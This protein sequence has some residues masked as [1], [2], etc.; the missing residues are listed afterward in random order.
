MECKICS[1]EVCEHPRI[2]IKDRI[3]ECVDCGQ[4]SANNPPIK[5]AL[6]FY[7][8]RVDWS[9]GIYFFVCRDCYYEHTH[10]RRAYPIKRVELDLDDVNKLWKSGEGMMINPIK[11]DT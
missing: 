9:S 8:G 3:Y 10:D 4:A 2:K 5:Y 1:K 11:G 7:E 6:P